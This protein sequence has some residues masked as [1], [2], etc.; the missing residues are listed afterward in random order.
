M[1]IVLFD[2]SI[3]CF[4]LESL[5]VSRFNTV[6]HDKSDY[7]ENL[8]MNTTETTFRNVLILQFIYSHIFTGMYQ[9]HLSLI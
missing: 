8:I 4:Y 2:L 3:Q 9:N 5:K 7:G 1:C 6:Y